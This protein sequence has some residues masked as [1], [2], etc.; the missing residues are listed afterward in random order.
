MLNDFFQIK[1]LKKE[2][3][4][5]RCAVHFNAGH[6]VFAG[7]FPNQPVVPGVCTMALV[8]HLLEEEVGKN[9]QLNKAG[10]VKFLQLLL[11]EDQPEIAI[12]FEEK[13]NHIH[14]HATFML[15]EKTVFKMSGV[16]IDSL[17]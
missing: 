2:P 3:G 9:L 15:A 8:K 11:P 13:E 14:A 10:N 5:V 1:D 7:H 4:M 17:I 6:P 16:Y 12:S